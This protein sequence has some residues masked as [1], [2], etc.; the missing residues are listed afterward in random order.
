MNSADVDAIVVAD[1]FAGSVT[2]T[3]WGLK[4]GDG[5]VEAEGTRECARTTRRAVRED[6]A[7][8]FYDG[9]APE[10][11]EPIKIVRREVTLSVT[12]WEERS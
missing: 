11:M 10:E 8:G 1:N 2:S 4:W 7:K 12:P 3:E 9:L 6:I 5:E